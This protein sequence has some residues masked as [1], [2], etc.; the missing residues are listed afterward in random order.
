MPNP[1]DDTAPIVIL[2]HGLWRTK[3]SMQSLATCDTY[4]LLLINQMHIINNT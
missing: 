4:E 2:L 3:H 1:T